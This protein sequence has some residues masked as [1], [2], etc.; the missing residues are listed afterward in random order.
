MSILNLLSRVSA[1]ERAMLVALVLVGSMIWLSN[2]WRNWDRANRKLRKARAELAQQAVWLDNADRFQAELKQSLSKLDP[3]STLDASALVALVD[4]LAREGKLKH[5]LGSPV[6]EAGGAF[7][8]HSL[9]ISLQNVPLADL[10]A[11]ERRVRVHYPYAN[12][13]ALSL[14]AN[15]ADPRLLNARLTIVSHELR[16]AGRAAAAEPA[17]QKK[18][19]KQ[20]AGKQRSA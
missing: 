11:F 1:R 6:S 3:Q 5:E 18:T 2:L 12:L 14:S 10:V 17:E 19:D 7:V 8:R 15:K 4:G 16:G 13:E 9:R 20:D